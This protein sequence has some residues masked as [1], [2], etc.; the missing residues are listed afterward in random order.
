MRVETA[1]NRMLALPGA[2]VEG[3]TFTDA[4]IIVAVLPRRRRLRCQC[5]FT[6]SS[7]YD[8]SRRRWRHIDAGSSQL[9]I[10]ADIR[11]MW[12][13]PCRRVRTE[14]VDWARP[15][16]RHTS[17]FEDV[18]AWLAQRMDKTAVSELMRCS[19]EA[20]AHIVERVV[21]DQLDDRRLD[22]LYRIGVDEISYKRGHNYVTVVADHERPR[23][24]WVAEG[25]D[26]AALASFFE[27][28]GPE[29]T[30]RL[31]AISMDLSPSFRR[32]A[33]E[34]APQALV[35]FDPFHVAQ[36]V[37]RALDSV[38][39]ASRYG[40]DDKISKKEWGQ[41]RAALRRGAE[42]LTSRQKAVL[43]RLRQSRYDVGLAWELKESFRDIYR[44]DAAEAK[45]ALMDWIHEAEASSLRAFVN[46]AR[47]MRE[48][49]D[50]VIAA[51][52][53]G[54]SN[55]RLEGINAKI[56]LINRRGY[57]HHSAAALTSMIYLCMGGL[58]VRLPTRT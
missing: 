15:G 37:H 17:D 20:V 24:V 6:C 18:V 7:R 48:H 32:V 10:E 47:Q 49:F 42:R 58:E 1:F 54:I 36:L 45:A 12:C 16:A 27:A 34:A 33:A 5:G 44:L 56:R 3:V 51:I 31:K 21:A 23:V 22:D 39:R 25:K 52:E 38:F 8:K 2:W 30:A 53:E 29:R 19:W 13:R 14:V 40:S 26:K 35:C 4:G 43:S 9:W 57:G 46:L 50:G 11:R 55:S 41:A 28:L